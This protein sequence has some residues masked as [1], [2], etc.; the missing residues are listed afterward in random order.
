MAAATVVTLGA[1]CALCGT[2]LVGSDVGAVE[3]GHLVEIHK[4][5]G[6][7][8]GFLLCVECA[9]LADFPASITLN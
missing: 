4:R 8:E 3:G 9:V 7:A 5:G 6:G 1:R 2:P